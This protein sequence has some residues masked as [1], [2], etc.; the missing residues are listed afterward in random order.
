MSSS[1]TSTSESTI[2]PDGST[3][4][5]QDS[6]TGGDGPS[7]DSPPS[8]DD[9]PLSPPVDRTA[10]GLIVFATMIALLA[11]ILYQVNKKKKEDA[12]KFEFFDNLESSQ[13]R[14]SLPP[15]VAE[16]ASVKSSALSSGWVPG[17]GKPPKGSPGEL[18]GQALMKRAISDIPL[19]QHM[20]KEAQ[21]MYRLHNKNMCSSVQWRTFQSSEAMVSAEVEEV[22]REAEGVEAGWSQV[23]WRQAAQYHA[24]LKKRHE[25]EQAKAK[26][27][28]RKRAEVEANVRKAKAG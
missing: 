18:V 21:G 10:L 6:S 25:E 16:Y 7:F 4:P 26:A 15:T 27:V 2:N 19:I 8:A 5:P 28:A 17:S 3:V 9:L 20:Q 24:M 13:Y 12:S 23:I 14:I 22:R 1:Y 11:A